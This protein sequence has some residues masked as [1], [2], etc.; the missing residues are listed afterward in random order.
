MD[1]P[2]LIRIL[3]LLY[4]GE[5]AVKETLAG[6]AEGSIQPAEAMERLLGDADADDEIY[7]FF[8]LVRGG[9]R[10]IFDAIGGLV[11]KEKKEK[12]PVDEALLLIVA[13]LK[14]RCTCA[15]EAHR[16]LKRFIGSLR[17]V[18]S[19]MHA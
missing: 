2:K 7:C 11:A 3:S 8:L 17:G 4:Q 6:V 18:R 15:L 16:N 9:N 10:E 12:L 19:P 1:N 14:K 5:K 13:E